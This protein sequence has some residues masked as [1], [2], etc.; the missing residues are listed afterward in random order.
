ML[1]DSLPL[2]LPGAS[3]RC[4]APILFLSQTE[5]VTIAVCDGIRLGPGTLRQTRVGIY[6][7]RDFMT[8]LEQR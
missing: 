4:D 2:T 7:G 6:V 5:P 1:H 8:S 3:H